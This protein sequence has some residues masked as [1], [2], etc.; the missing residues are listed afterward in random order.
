MNNVM[1]VNFEDTVYQKEIEN[2]ISLYLSVKGIIL[3]TKNPSMK[4][5]P[6]MHDLNGKFIKDLM[7]KYYHIVQNISENI[8]ER[9]LSTDI[10]ESKIILTLKFG[11][12]LKR[13][14][15]Q[16]KYPS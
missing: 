8:G 10:L 15:K 1:S 2:S 3:V 5:T 9:T 11:K 12:D 7:N 14:E 13:E 6:G 4:K 16:N